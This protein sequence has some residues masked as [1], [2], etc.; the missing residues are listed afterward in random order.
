MRAIGLL[1]KQKTRR[2]E[3]KFEKGSIRK[4]KN[5]DEE[6]GGNDGLAC[7]T[8]RTGGAFR[9][10]ACVWVCVSGGTRR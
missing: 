9:K 2:G 10:F 4:V 6:N 7:A 3:N 8:G 1:S 5:K